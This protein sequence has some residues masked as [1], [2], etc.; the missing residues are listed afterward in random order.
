M[1]RPSEWSSGVPDWNVSGNDPVVKYNLGRKVE[2][3]PIDAL[4]EYFSSWTKLKHSV[5]WLLKIKRDLT[6]E[7]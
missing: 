2:A 6:I 7:K 4:S 5:G 3:H 1:G